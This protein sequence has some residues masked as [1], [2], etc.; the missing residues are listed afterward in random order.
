MHIVVLLN[1]F[2]QLK[3]WPGQFKGLEKGY[4]TFHT[5]QLFA[6]LKLFKVDFVFL[7]EL[8]N[9]EQFGSK[10]SQHPKESNCYVLGMVIL[11]IL[12]SKA[13][14]LCCSNLVVMRKIIEGEHPERPK[15]PEAAWFMDDLWGMLK[16]CWSH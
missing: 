11:E 1:H 16:Q 14:F 8:L 6:T 3:K 2:E 9:P 4:E 5:F 7:M 15:G 10:S 13:P 12:T